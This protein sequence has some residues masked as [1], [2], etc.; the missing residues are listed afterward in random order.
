MSNDAPRELLILRHAKS[1]WDTDAPSDF[2]RPLSKRGKR[3]APRMGEWLAEQGLAPDAVACSP[4]RRA[5]MTARRVLDELADAEPRIDYDD[6]IYG[7]T[8]GLLADVIADAPRGA[9]RLLVVGHN[10]GFEDF[11]RWLASETPEMP[12]NGKLMPTCALAWFQL[13]GGFDELA[14]GCARLHGIARPK[15]VP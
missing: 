9:R 1:A 14:P 15:E 5:R 8:V 12:P 4:A 13:P 11:V 6:R 3:D 7:A 10:P 2:E